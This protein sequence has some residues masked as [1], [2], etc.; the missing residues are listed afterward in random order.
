VTGR[1][2]LPGFA[3]AVAVAAV[4][5]CAFSHAAAQKRE[6]MPRVGILT[7]APSKAAKP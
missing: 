5:A 2:A 4:I 6:T 1:C 7:P 3:A